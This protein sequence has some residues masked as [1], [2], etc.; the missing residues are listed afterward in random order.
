MRAALGSALCYLYSSF[1]SY[2]SPLANPLST[3]DHIGFP[4][5]N[6]TSQVFSNI[7][8][9]ELDQYVKHVL[10]MRYYLRYTDDQLFLSTSLNELKACLPKV[11][12][13]LRDHLQL[14]LH[15]EKIT[16]SHYGQGIDW[17]GYHMYWDH[18]LVRSTTRKRLWQ[19]LQARFVTYSQDMIAAH[20]HNDGLSKLQQTAAS[21]LGILAHAT[22]YQMSAKISQWIGV[23]LPRLRRVK[24]L[25]FLK[26]ANKIWKRKMQQLFAI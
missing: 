16:L 21:Y 15:P 6:V 18:R 1:I 8:M 24:N 2:T 4:I 25:F 5:G 22:A 10:K 20:A 14:T 19:R 26:R 12:S 7:Y 23:K 9:N 13:F 3:S 17:L 11:Q